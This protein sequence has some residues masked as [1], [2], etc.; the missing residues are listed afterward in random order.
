VAREL[1]FGGMNEAGLVV[2][3]LWLDQTLYPAPDARPAAN[4]LDWIQYQ[5]DNCR[6]VGE[7]MATDPILRIDPLAI[8]AR[9]HYLVCDAAGDCATIEFL[10]GK[11]VCHRCESLHFPALANDTYADC[12]AYLGE[13]PE[14][15][16]PSAK[17]RA[18]YRQ[19]KIDG[20]FAH[21]ATRAAVFTP[22]T[23]RQD[24]DYAFA[25]L[26]D[27]CQGSQ[28]VWR[29]VYD[30]V[31]RRIYYRTRSHPRERELDLKGIDFAAGPA[32]FF[33]LHPRPAALERL[34]SILPGRA[35]Q[36]QELTERYHRRYVEAY[37]TQSWVKRGF[38][39]MIPLMDVALL[40][41]HAE[42]EAGT[43]GPETSLAG[44]EIVRKGLEAR[45]GKQAAAALQSLHSFGA[46]DLSWRKEKNLP[47]E[48]FAMRPNKNLTLIGPRTK[49]GWGPGLYEYG[50]D[51]RNGWE[52]QPGKR[53]QGFEGKRL[54]E[55]REESEFTLDEPE[56]Y[57]S[58]RCLGRLPF[59]GRECWAVR[60]VQG[61]G[62]DEIH[63][64]DSADGL[65]AGAVHYSASGQ[66]W[67]RNTFGDYR[68][69]GG[70]RLPTRIVGRAQY[71]NYAI[72]LRSI[73]VNTLA[74]SAFK[75]IATPSSR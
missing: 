70:F 14:P 56:D 29:L 62:K 64:Y 12:A 26:D 33:D 31:N 34:S 72:R 9:A 20:R 37:V 53:P 61:T 39:D 50:F 43:T 46:S 47:C 45:G 3:N 23:L 7:V 28:T 52:T 5:L 65:P 4:L 42:W 40:Q 68:S 27:V 8:P 6:T 30:I 75:S 57:A 60:V 66:T 1:P 67:I 19:R 15:N 18:L 71:Y 73:E 10:Q 13:H 24:L 49:T 55:C 51:G 17:L 38:G 59:D 11:M 35:P 16:L 41:L 44:D 69:F 54:D 74:D 22:G 21:A 2:E 25:T 36:F 32:R 58:L 63:Y 48:L